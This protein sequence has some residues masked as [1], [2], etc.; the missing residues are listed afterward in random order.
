MVLFSPRDPCSRAAQLLFKNLRISTLTLG[1]E[2]ISNGD[3]GGGGG[4]E[5]REGG[6]SLSHRQCKVE[7]KTISNKVIDFKDYNKD[8]K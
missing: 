5:G 2:K 7:H 6:V 1:M 3:G 8:S 4:R